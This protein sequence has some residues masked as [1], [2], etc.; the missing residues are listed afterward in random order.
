MVLRS[1][2][3]NIKSDDVVLG[4]PK[5]SFA[6]SRSFHKLLNPNDKAGLEDEEIPSSKTRSF[7][8]KDNLGTKE[9]EGWGAKRND[10]RA[11]AGAGDHEK[12]Y[13]RNQRDRGDRAVSYT[14]LTLPTKRIV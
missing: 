14:H 1:I 2:R 4:P 7:R 13:G 12:P 3:A 11:G 6:S 8:E 10:G 5:T 9:R